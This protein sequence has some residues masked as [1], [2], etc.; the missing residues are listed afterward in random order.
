MFCPFPGAHNPPGSWTFLLPK[1][2]KSIPT[3]EPLCRLLSLPA[4]PPPRG[5][6]VLDINVYLPDLVVLHPTPPCTATPLCP[7]KAISKV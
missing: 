5:W 2:A 3:P 7:L 6:L 4:T 1:P